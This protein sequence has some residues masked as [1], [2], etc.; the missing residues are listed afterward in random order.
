MNP[1]KNR[2]VLYE[3]VARTQ[4]SRGWTTSARV[5]QHTAPSTERTPAETPPPAPVSSDSHVPPDEAPESP[6]SLQVAEGRVYLALGWPQLTVL[7]VLL[8]VVIVVSFQVGARSARPLPAEGPN[9]EEILETPPATPPV[10]NPPPALQTGHR[11]PGAAQTPPAP[12]REERPNA[13]TPARTEHPAPPRPEPTAP[14]PYAFKEGRTYVVVQHVAKSTAGQRAAEAIQ[15]FLSSNGVPCVVRTGAS[16]RDLE[17]VVIE[18]FLTRQDDS[19]AAD[20]EKRRAAQLQE[21]IR[22]LGQEYRIIGGYAFE[23][24]YLRTF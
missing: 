21:R 22:K 18:E 12:P 1:R 6:P 8:I 11:P 23:G 24:C 15:Q 3:V 10:T 14:E 9:L 16:G 13:P 20:R 7:G 19:T 17:V 5:T 2:P 4:R